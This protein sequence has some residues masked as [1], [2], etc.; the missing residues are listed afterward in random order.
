MLI[1]AALYLFVGIAY[2]LIELLYISRA[3]RIEI[4]SLFRLMYSAIYGFLPAIMLYKLDSG[5]LSS[6]Y[7]T[8][9]EYGTNMLIALI[10][11]V[12]EYIILTVVYNGTRKS[13]LYNKP[14]T[15]LSINTQ[16]VSLTLVCI[17]GFLSLILWTRAYGSV[18]NFIINADAIRANYSN[19]YNP[20]AFMEHFTKVFA[21]SFFVVIALLIREKR[22]KRTKLYTWFL[23]LTT[24]VGAITVML[25]TD[26]R[27]AIGTLIIV[28]VLYIINERVENSHLSVKKALIT[29]VIVVGAAFIAI[30]A[31]EG[32]MNAFRGL[33][34]GTSEESRGILDIVIS[35]FGYTFHS[36][37]MAVKTVMDNPFQTML[38]N[39]LL[40][41]ITAWL[42]SRFIP[43]ELP[44]DIWNY[45]TELLREVKYFYGQA[46]SDFVST[47][48]YWF[49]PIGILLGPALMGWLIKKLETM[50]R[51]A[52]YSPYLMAVYARFMYYAVWWVSHCSI[53][54]TV[55]ALFGM[56][57]VHLITKVVEIILRSAARTERTDIGVKK[58]E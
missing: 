20:F 57:L 45:N 44:I 35:E 48:L 55:L 25:C 13:R 34:D 9:G 19:I 4:I 39:D 1:L 47:T 32:V 11:S 5:T 27:G 51:R 56:F 7:M 17:M 54:Y 28:T 14:Y 26:A 50:F 2:V 43:F 40:G 46:P 36:Q 16:K 52:A 8:L 37:A 12:I 38:F 24:F 33:S 10:V 3:K 22:K 58:H 18:M 53:Q 29:L 42:P 41:G 21:F 15:D 31:S 6:M 30:V 49:G 23:L